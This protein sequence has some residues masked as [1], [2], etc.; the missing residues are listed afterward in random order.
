MLNTISI[1][2]SKFEINS[3]LP[4]AYPIN[5]NI[6]LLFSEGYDRVLRKNGTLDLSDNNDL[7]HIGNVG[8]HNI[9]KRK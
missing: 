2:L 7:R 3:S 9:D 8:R 6:I 5:E 1:T 4:L